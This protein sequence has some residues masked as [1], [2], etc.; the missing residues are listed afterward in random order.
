MT[1]ASRLSLGRTADAVLR[2]VALLGVGTVTVPAAYLG[3][4]TAAAWGDPRRHASPQPRPGRAHRFAVLVP[5]HDEASVVAATVESLVAQDHP[6]SHFSVNVVADNC[7][8]DT[9]AVA[10]S[11][12]ARVYERHD[13]DDP[14]K[15][16]ALNWLIGQVG[17]DDVDVVVIVD[18]DTIADPGMLAAFDRAFDA[19]AKVAQGDYG[20]LDP[21]ANSAVALRYAALACRHRLRP[22]GRTRLGASCGLYGNGMA[23]RSDVMRSRS[24]S[25]H[26][27][28]DAEFQLELLLDGIDVTYCP[29]ARIVAEMPTSWGGA[30]TQHQRWELGR[31]QLVRR[32]APALA[33][34]AV[35]GRGRVDRVRRRAAADAL[36][37]LAV[38]PLSLL[39]AAQLAAV[40]V[41]V[42]SRIASPPG[43]SRGVVAVALLGSAATV[44]HVIA[45]LRIVDAPRAIW[46]SLWSAPRL[47][48]WKLGV[49]A[50]VARRPEEVEWTRTE[51]NATV[52]D[53]SNGDVAMILD[54][55]AAAR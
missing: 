43:R 46:R 25:G 29:D 41:G 36:I 13:P 4:L 38:P 53:G 40:G 11:S 7:S 23:F 30:V 14:G 24:W 6:A 32:F 52:P 35:T 28:E 51:R 9:A 18:A 16:S 49:L 50:G 31:A 26:L 48:A 54:D 39:V 2:P 17:L 47:I 20:V 21:E 27:V 42:A 22:L 55:V 8:D 33:R 44:V 1:S 15:G 5:A 12:G 3:V 19:G 45:A 10:R 37:D 34:A